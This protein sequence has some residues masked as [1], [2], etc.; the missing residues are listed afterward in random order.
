VTPAGEDGVYLGG[1]DDRVGWKRQLDGVKQKRPR[2]RSAEAT[3]KRDQLLER[4]P[5]LEL[6]VV[7]AVDHDVGD[8]LEAV[9][10]QQMR[11]GVGRERRERILP[12]DSPL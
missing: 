4:A 3:V 6:G 2:L 5:L 12:F 1:S 11:P 8:V 7:E 10:T 9:G